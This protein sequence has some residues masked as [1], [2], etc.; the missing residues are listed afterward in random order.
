VK[1]HIFKPAL[2]ARRLPAASGLIG[3]ASLCCVALASCG[4]D[5]G[6]NTGSSN[7]GNGSNRATAS[8]QHILFR[9]FSVPI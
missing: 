6:G 1:A 3:I 7:P 2:K 4:G 8:V 9:A 5:G